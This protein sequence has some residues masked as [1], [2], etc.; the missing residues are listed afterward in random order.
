MP[1][2]CP[3]LCRSVDRYVEDG[4]CFDQFLDCG[5]NLLVL[6]DRASELLLDIAYTD[7]GSAIAAVLG[8]KGETR[9]EGRF[10]QPS[11]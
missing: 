2:T 3:V 9:Q 1:E 4:G 5:D 8:L 11:A 7:W 6:P 10:V